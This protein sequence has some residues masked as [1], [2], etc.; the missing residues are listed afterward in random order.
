[1]HELLRRARTRGGVDWDDDGPLQALRAVDR[2]NFDRML[3]GIDHTLIVG[4]TA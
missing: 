1:M 3:I 2:H 4:K